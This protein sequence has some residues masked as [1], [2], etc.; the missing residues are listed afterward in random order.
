[1]KWWKEVVLD[2]VVS[3]VI[4]AAV[5]FPRDWLTLAILVY[6]G[7]MIFLKAAVYFNPTVAGSIKKSKTPL[8]FFH[9]SYGLNTVL[10][11]AGRHWI[12]AGLWLGIWVLSYLTYRRVILQK[13]AT[14]KGKR[15]V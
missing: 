7:L 12:A 13:P 8:W 3:L 9:L 15:L 11:L 2:V 14:G 6:S 10:L 5:L 1:M 4:V